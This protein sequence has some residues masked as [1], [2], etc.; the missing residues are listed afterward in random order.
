MPGDPWPNSQIVPPWVWSPPTVLHQRQGLRYDDIK[1]ALRYAFR[2]GQSDP[3]ATDEDTVINGIF[4]SMF[5][6][7]DL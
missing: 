4:A 2:A 3:T 7:K 5:D 6:G 1:S